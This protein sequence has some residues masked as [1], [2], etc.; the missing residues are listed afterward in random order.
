M[1]ALGQGL[2]EAGC[3]SP[4]TELLCTGVYTIYLRFDSVVLGSS[5]T[6]G[7]YTLTGSSLAYRALSVPAAKPGGLFCELPTMAA[8]VF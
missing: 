5:N 6:D 3:S 8:Q 2:V 7:P 4:Y 1:D